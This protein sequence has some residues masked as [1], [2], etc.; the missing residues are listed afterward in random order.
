M[1]NSQ[2]KVK[3][4]YPILQLERPMKNS[5]PIKQRN[6]KAN[7]VFNFEHFVDEISL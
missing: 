6:V 2:A 4:G 1:N 3:I 5:E 7:N